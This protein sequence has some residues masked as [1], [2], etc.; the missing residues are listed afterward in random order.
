MKQ[1]DLVTLKITDLNS[2]GEG[3]GR[4]DG[5]VVFVADTITG[6]CVQVRVDKVK[7]KYA[8]AVLKNIFTSSEY[9]IRPRCIVADKCGGCQWQHIDETY[10][11]E[12]KQKQVT[13]A[14][15]RIGKLEPVEI[16][17]ILFAPQTLNYRNKSTYSLKLS[18][19]GKVQA[20]YFRKGSHKIV[21][22]NQCPV[23]DERLHPLLTNIK[24]DI[25]YQGWSIYDET[26]HQWQLR[27]LS[28]RIGVNT[29]EMLL[30]LISTDAEL[31]NLEKQAQEWLEQYPKLVG[32]CLN[33]NS[34][35]TNVI[36]G[37]ET[38]TIAG[39][40]YLKEIFSGVE[41]AIGADTFFQINTTAA[42]MLLQKIIE[43][44]DLQG[45]EVLVDAYCGIG[46][47]TLPLAKLV[48]KAL[49]IESSLSSVEQAINNARI[50]Q[51][52]NVE[53]LEGKVE[54]CLSQLA[55]KPDLVILDPPR[56]GCQPKVIETLLSIQPNKIVYVS[57][58]PAT[59]ARD[60]KILIDS[61]IYQLDYVQC[62]DFFPQTKHVETVVILTK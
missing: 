21:N 25:H 27:H 62:A 15:Q 4:V 41:L 31:P 59:L 46:T 58:N 40:A 6:D 14:L 16:T 34:D 56:K 1:G 54:D 32:V 53:F 33:I 10:Q 55:F 61:G 23:Q 36:F 35:R 52:E 11:R 7:N 37:R 5:K 28:L 3:V 30:T 24:Q 18:A 49:G 17:P 26:D 44:L 9:R 60:L 47:F 8:R 43:Q 42:E 50:N 45:S 22:L 2:S 57:C 39:K 12:A 51:I 20:G 38:K 13:E 29:G 19:T 48:Q